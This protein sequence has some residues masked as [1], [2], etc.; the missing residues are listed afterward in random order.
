[1]SADDDPTERIY[2]PPSVCHLPALGLKERKEYS[3]KGMRTFALSPAFKNTFLKPLSSMAGRNMALCGLDMYS[4]QTS[5][6]SKEPVLVNVN[7]TPS[8]SAEMSEYSN[9]V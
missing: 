2:S 7:S 4:W 1:M 3:S 8:P 9:V 6:P 5:A